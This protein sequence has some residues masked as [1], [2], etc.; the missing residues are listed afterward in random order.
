MSTKTGTAPTCSGALAVAMKEYGG[1]MTSS[2]ISTPD[3]K[4]GHL[5]SGGA[6]AHAEAVVAIVVARKLLLELPRARAVAPPVP[7][8]AAQH[9]RH[10]V[11]RLFPN[12]RPAREIPSGAVLVRR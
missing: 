7:A 6:A 5:Q 1:T 3:G 8:R 2:P 4:H 9:V 12:L 10:R 11:N